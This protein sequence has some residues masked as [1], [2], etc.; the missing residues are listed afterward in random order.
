MTSAASLPASELQAGVTSVSARRIGLIGDDHN[1]RADGSDLPEEVLTAFEGVDL[2]V[3]LGHMGVRD[4]LARGVLDRLAAV[5]PVLA[6]QDYSTDQ[7]GNAFVTPA[8]GDR[9]AGLTRVIETKGVRIG[10]VHNLGRGPGR[11]IA[12]PPGGLPELQGVPVAAALAEKFGGP[13][14]LVAYASSHRPAAITAQGVLFVNPGSPT[15]PKGPG[16]TPGQRALGTV[17]ILDIADGVAAFEIVELSLLT[18]GTA[19]DG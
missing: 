6:V 18:G 12:T 14:D 11:E 10:A 1:G 16:R 13:V 17:G 3:H 19:T 5:A 7:D 9:V 8:D 15:Y 2:I 4:L